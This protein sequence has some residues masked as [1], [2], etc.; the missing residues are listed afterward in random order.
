MKIFAS[1][2]NMHSLDKLL[3][4]RQFTGKWAMTTDNSLK[5]KNDL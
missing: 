5:N 4:K 2:V 1:N 3:R